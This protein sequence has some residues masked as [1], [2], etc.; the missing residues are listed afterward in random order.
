MSLNFYLQPGSFLPT[1]NVSMSSWI[2]HPCFSFRFVI[3]PCQ[4]AA[5]LASLYT[6]ACF[7]P[8]LFSDLSSYCP[9]PQLV[10]CFWL[11][12]AK[13]RA[14]PLSVSLVTNEPHLMSVPLLTDNLPTTPKEDCWPAFLAALGGVLLQDL[15]C[16][17]SSHPLNHRCP[18]LLTLGCF[19]C[20]ESGLPVGCS[21]APCLDL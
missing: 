15:V 13:G 5:L 4:V 20:L 8:T 2:S 16:D 10:D 21:P 6:Y 7:T 1:L 14:C 17:V 9:R 18:V 3:R 19:F 12:G 11:K